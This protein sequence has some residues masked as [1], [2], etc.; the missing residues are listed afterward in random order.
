MSLNIIIF[1][2]S[3]LSANVVSMVSL[4]TTAMA[5]NSAA[6]S[7][8]LAARTTSTRGNAASALASASSVRG[9]HDDWPS[10]L[11]VTT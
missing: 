11:S 7:T 8:G 5:A 10:S 1:M 3:F 2:D 4:Q 6:A 9:V